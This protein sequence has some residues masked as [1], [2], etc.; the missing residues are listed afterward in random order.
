MPRVALLLEYKGKHFTINPGQNKVVIRRESKTL[1]GKFRFVYFK[2]RNLIENVSPN[3]FFPI[4]K[5]AYEWSM[6]KRKCHLGEEPL[7]FDMMFGMR[8]FRSIDGIES[9]KLVSAY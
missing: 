6:N 9:C 8:R 3:N 1:Q 5:T 7:P 2:N 4:L